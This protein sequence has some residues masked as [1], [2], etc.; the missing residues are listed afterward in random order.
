M[1][2]ITSI[3]YLACMNSYSLSFHVQR[4]IGTEYQR[5]RFD[6]A[7]ATIRQSCLSHLAIGIWCAHIQSGQ[8]I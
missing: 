1:C 4:D 7:N 3:G 2:L 8:T 5:Y 6:L